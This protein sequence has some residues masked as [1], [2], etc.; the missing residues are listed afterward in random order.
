MAGAHR[1]AVNAAR[2]DLRTPA[3]LNGV[4][5]ADHNRP[6]R[7]EGGHQQQQ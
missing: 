5:D 1:I 7:H 2:L 4:V 3:P 6:G